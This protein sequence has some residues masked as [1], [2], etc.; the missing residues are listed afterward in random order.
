MQLLLAQAPCH[1]SKLKE[2][3]QLLLQLPQLCS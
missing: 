2:Q 1:P 3:Q